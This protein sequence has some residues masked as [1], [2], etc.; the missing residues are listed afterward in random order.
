MLG[1]QFRIL[2]LFYVN[3]RKAAS[4]VMDH[5]RLV[6]A[7]VAALVVAVTI[8]MAAGVQQSAEYSMRMQVAQERLL[9][10]D[11]A[12]AAQEEF[13]LERRAISRQLDRRTLPRGSSRW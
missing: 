4:A 5:G 8:A 11:A 13:L 10:V 1:E 7:A 9:A 6:F 12:P 3:P 2:F